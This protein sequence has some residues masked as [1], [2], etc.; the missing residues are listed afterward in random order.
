M[1]LK[2]L[3]LPRNVTETDLS[4]MFSEYGKVLSCTLIKDKETGASKGFGF[5]EMDS[6]ESGNQAIEA[7]H[8]KKL[9]GSRIRVKPAE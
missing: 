2:L 5:V 4:T 6:D 9:K 7:F 8:K 3:N 1:Q